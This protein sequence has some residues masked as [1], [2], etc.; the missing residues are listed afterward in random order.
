MKT[1]L[2][3]IKVYSAIFLFTEYNKKE[4]SF[5]GKRRTFTKKSKVGVLSVHD[6]LIYNF[7]FA[8]SNFKALSYCS[9]FFLRSF[10]V[11]CKYKNKIL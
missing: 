11:L 4:R 2:Q 3:F 1:Y 6:V 5:T 10:S 8:K 9:L 7:L